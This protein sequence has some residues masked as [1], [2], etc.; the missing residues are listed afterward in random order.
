MTEI[1]H[2]NSILI[3]LKKM[4]QLSE[5]DREKIQTCYN[6]FYSDCRSKS[7]WIEAI[8]PEKLTEIRNILADGPKSIQE[9]FDS[10]YPGYSK[11]H[12][13]DETT[14]L[15]NKLRSSVNRYEMMN[16]IERHRDDNGHCRCYKYYLIRIVEKPT[17]EAIAR[18]YVLN[19]FGAMFGISNKTRQINGNYTFDLN[20]TMIIDTK[21]VICRDIGTIIVNNEGNARHIFHEVSQ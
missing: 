8:K 17:P 20:C 5:T 3:E 21:R 19:K 6:K 1:Y 18:I 2:D 10:L 15:M 13:Y 16:L 14:S 9:I 4:P 12:T 11:D 7:R